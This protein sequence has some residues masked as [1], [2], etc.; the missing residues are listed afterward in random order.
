VFTLK[1]SAAD[2]AFDRDF[3]PVVTTDGGF[4]NPNPEVSP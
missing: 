4:S 3:G 2:I 1:K